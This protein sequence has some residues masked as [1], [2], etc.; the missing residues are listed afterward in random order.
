ME[1][2]TDNKVTSL[3]PDSDKSKDSS[4]AL[5]EQAALKLLEENGV[6]AGLNLRE[7][8]EDAGVNR[9]LVYHHFGSREELLRSA[10][11]RD[12]QDRLDQ[13]A[14]GLSL[15]FNARI[16]QMLRTMVQ[17]QPALKLAMLL[18]LDGQ[19]PV[20]LAPL[21]DAWLETFEADSEAEKIDDDI[22]LE[23]FLVLISALS[24]GYALMRESFAEE[25]DIDPV[26]LDWRLETVLQRVLEKLER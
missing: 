21:K 25:F 5:L 26:N 6:L 18:I 12:L 22:D 23:A 1:K 2:S 3:Q 17:H 9:A 8:A 20:R 14:Q 10:L 4:K 11:A 7:V 16:R 19:E 13:I 24:Y 15:P